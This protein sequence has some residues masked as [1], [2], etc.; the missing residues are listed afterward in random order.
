MLVSSNCRIDRPLP[1]ITVWIIRTVQPMDVIIYITIQ[2]L[3]L[4]LYI[5]CYCYEI[6]AHHF[7]QPSKGRLHLFIFLSGLFD[8]RASSILS[9]CYGSTGVHINWS[10]E[11]INR[12][13]F[14]VCLFKFQKELL[15][16]DE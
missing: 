3:L 6:I 8:P 13:T 11:I 16:R 14:S 9:E 7:C 12:P 1:E 2:I 15:D 4:L 10:V 5:D